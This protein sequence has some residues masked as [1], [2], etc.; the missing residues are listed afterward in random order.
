[1]ISKPTHVPTHF[2]GCDVGKASVFIF[3][4]RDGRTRTIPNNGK[5][6]AAFAAT[7]D[8][9]CLAIC[10]ATGG[11]EAALLDALL[12]ANCPTHRADAR[13]VKAFIRSFGTLGKTDAIDARALA[14][15]G[16]ERHAQLARWQAPD[17]QRDTL[18]ALILTR[19]DL[20]DQRQACKN[21]LAAP[22]SAAVIPFLK[23][24]LA[25]LQAQIG[26]IE[27]EARALI[28]ATPSLAQAVRQL[29]S[30]KG[31]GFLT[32]A[33][34][35]ALMPELGS[36]NRKQAACLAGLAP[37]PSQ[38][39][40]KDA[41]R[42]T[43]GG[44]PEV[45]KILFMAALTAAKHDPKMRDFYQRLLKEGKKKLVATVA[46]MR[47]MIVIANAMLRQPAQTNPQ[48]TGGAVGKWPAEATA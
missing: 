30:M 36:V 40:T 38:S 48:S 1:M 3:D 43:K 7:L 42:R 13:K 39:G 33:S 21:R 9:S 19:R 11:Y 4:S 16:Q 15:Y 20:V 17:V 18:Q 28:K 29:C 8:A 12:A 6:L 14:R 46:V 5:Q 31:M 45:R 27:A 25:C 26:A 35:V 32:A 34:L 37:H 10:E 44:R 2:I 47:K 24:L 41:Y 22:G 23:Q